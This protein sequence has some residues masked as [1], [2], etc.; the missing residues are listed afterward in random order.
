MTLN[1]STTIS[2]TIAT[3]VPTLVKSSCLQVGM[4]P[5]VAVDVVWWFCGSVV[6]AVVN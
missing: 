2:T 6:V 3:K 5:V 1:I 4:V